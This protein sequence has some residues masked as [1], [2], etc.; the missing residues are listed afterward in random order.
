MEL[1]ALHNEFDKDLPRKRMS[2]VFDFFNFSLEY[3]SP[4][5]PP[6]SSSR[7]VPG[8][9]RPIS[10]TLRTVSGGLRTIP[11][12]SNTT[13]IPCS[14]STVGLSK[15]QKRNQ[16]KAMDKLLAASDIQVGGENEEKRDE[17][18]VK[19]SPVKEVLAVVEETKDAVEKKIKGTRKKLRQINDLESKSEELNEAE[20]EKV[21]K[22]KE[23]E[24][25][26]SLLLEK[27][28]I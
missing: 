25:E 13:V 7:S 10:P 26:L 14:S 2:R 17:K 5:R 27:V 22:K 11:G 16:K 1:S 9:P 18:L 8:A 21:N 12:A 3:N 24:D 6:P 20:E 19:V 28:K 15:N 23:L 4:S